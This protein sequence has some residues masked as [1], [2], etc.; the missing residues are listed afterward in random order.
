M[1]QGNIHLHIEPVQRS[2]GQSLIMRVA[3]QTASALRNP[4]T[5]K[6]HNFKYKA[7]EIGGTL[8]ITPQGET[9]KRKAIADFWQKVERHHKRKDA[10]PGRTFSV[11]LPCELSKEENL[12]L[13]YAYGRW[14][15][16]TYGIGVQVTAHLLDSNNPHFHITISSCSVMP[17]D[18]L[19]KKSGNLIL[20]PCNTIIGFLRQNHCAQNGR[21]W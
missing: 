18:T 15:S 11:A 20:L 10:I 2:E 9:S 12:R 6:H 19:G 17:D 4:L 1:L 16:K 3:Y 8:L 7:S 13:M 14:L 5:H 21:T